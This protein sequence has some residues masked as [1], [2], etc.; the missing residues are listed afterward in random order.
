MICMFNDS[1]CAEL[2]KVGVA[3]IFW[4]HFTEEETEEE[5][6]LLKLPL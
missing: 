5:E 2:W 6:D 4:P 3:I 1:C